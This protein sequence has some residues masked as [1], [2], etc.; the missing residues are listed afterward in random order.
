M[1]TLP[2]DHH[3]YADTRIGPPIVLVASAAGLCSLLCCA[4]LERLN[5]YDTGRYAYALS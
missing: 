5:V 1:M 4:D 3:K 2:R